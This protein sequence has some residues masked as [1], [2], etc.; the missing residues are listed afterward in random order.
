MRLPE[1]VKKISPIG[2]TLEAME[3]GMGLLAEEAALRNRQLSVGTADGGLPLWE[4]YYSLPG[5]GDTVLRRARIRAAMAGIRTLTVEELKSLA[6]TVGGA[7]GAEVEESFGDWRVTLYALYEGRAPGDL[8][9][10]EEAIRRRKPAHL[11]VEVVPVAALRGTLT[12]YTALVGKTHLIV[13]GRME[14]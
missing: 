5:S 9:A 10:L 8:T 7:D 14:N 1:F 11:A 2:E 13:R 6:V 12:H 4:A 3:A